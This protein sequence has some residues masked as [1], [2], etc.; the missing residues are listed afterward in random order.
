MS[1]RK[2]IQIF[3]VIGFAVW[4]A[5]GRPLP[6]FSRAA[7]DN[8]ATGSIAHEPRTQSAFTVADAAAPA[9]PAAS[10]SPPVTLPS[11]G[12]APAL[13]VSGPAPAPAAATPQVDES[14]LRYFARNGDQRRLDAEMARLRAL[15]PTWQPPKNLFEPERAADPELDGMWKLYAAGRYAD[16]RSAIATRTLADPSWRPPKAL[17]DLL[18]QAEARLRMT[19]ASDTKQWEIVINVAAATPDLLTCQNVD[20]LWRLA[21]AFAGSQKLPRARDAYGYVLANCDNPQARLAT[22]QK[23]MALLTQSDLDILLKYQRGNEFAPVLDDLTRRRVGK[24]A[25]DPKLTAAPEDLAR[26]EALANGNTLSGDPLVLGWYYYRHSDPQKALDWFK[27]SSDREASAKAAEGYTLALNTL[28]RLID[29]EDFGYAWIG[30]AP[31]NLKAY[32]DVVTR[33]LGADPPIQ[34]EQPVMKRITEVIAHERNAPAGEQLGWYAYNIGQIR[35]AAHWFQSV[36]QW[37]AGYE[38]AAYGFAVALLRLNDKAGAQQVIRS[39]QERSARI[40]ALGKRRQSTRALPAV[41]APTDEAAAAGALADASPEVPTESIPLTPS[42]DRGSLPETAG[43]RGAGCQTSIPAS[44]L[45]PERALPRGWCLMDLNRPVEAAAA[46]AVAQRSAISRVRADAAYGS[47]L[48]D[49]RS[50]VTDRA[51]ASA[52]REPQG[53]TRLVEMTIGLLAQQAAAAYSDGRYSETIILLNER[54]RLAPEPNDL[55]VLKAYSYMKLRQLADAK[56]IF[57]AVAATG[58]HDGFR[59]LAAVEALEH[60]H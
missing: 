1:L 12:A 15:Y 21:E 32:L 27:M 46:F 2:A 43:N 34:I 56:R 7:T 9:P 22:V 18:D 60:P 14:A 45:S 3:G 42:R 28:G 16:L 4:I 29:A 44:T 6:D 17:S 49:L 25:E 54:A 30:K 39:W 20:L 38:P 36:L 26:V 19:N 59:G 55:L 5:A 37:Q 53:E 8:M 51:A 35:T 10:A 13:G 41:A 23:A 11:S 47:T 31:D 58:F 50:N 33:L 52:S 57:A 48:A 40:A 24:A